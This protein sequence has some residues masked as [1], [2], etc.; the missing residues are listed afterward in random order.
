MHRRIDMLLLNCRLRSYIPVGNNRLVRILRGCNTEKVKGRGRLRF[1][2]SD[3]GHLVLR[4]VVDKEDLIRL[5]FSLHA[6][7]K[8]SASA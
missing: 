5:V 3:V 8:C 2:V 7:S 6:V 1:G 4:S